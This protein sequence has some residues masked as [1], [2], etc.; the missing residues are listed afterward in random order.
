MTDT[1][2]DREMLDK[3]IPVSRTSKRIKIFWYQNFFDISKKNWS[4]IW[5]SEKKSK[6]CIKISK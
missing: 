1:R 6:K 3:V 5:I 4:D 2:T